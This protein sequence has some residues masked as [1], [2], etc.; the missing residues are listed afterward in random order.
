MNK[1]WKYLQHAKISRN[2]RKNTILNPKNRMQKIMKCRNYESED[3]GANYQ[4]PDITD[5]TDS[6]INFIKK[7]KKHK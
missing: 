4:K 6:L 1:K 5:I 7:Q 3:S 2:Q